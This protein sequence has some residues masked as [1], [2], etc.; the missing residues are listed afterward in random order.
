MADLSDCIK[1]EI[2]STEVELEVQGAIQELT[3]DEQIK[4]EQEEHLLD[5]RRMKCPQYYNMAHIPRRHKEFKVKD[6]KDETWQK[7]YENL[8]SKISKGAIIALLGNR[9]TGKTQM[10]CCLIGHTVFNEFNTGRYVK[11]LDMFLE[12]R[13]GMKNGCEKESMNEFLRPFTLVIDA[14]EVRSESDFENRMI[15]H[16]I[17]RRYDDRKTTIVISNDN[18][19]TFV[20]NIGLSSMDRIRETGAL[21]NFKNK[22]FRANKIS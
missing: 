4:K 11:A 13:E 10:A 15:D 16:I 20:K 7:N 2:D 21:I 9:G 5:S 6:N 12:I 22:S 14:Y 19:D 3:R 17:D 18:M 8:K 1:S